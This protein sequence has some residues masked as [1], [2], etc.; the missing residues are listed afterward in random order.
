MLTFIS[1]LVTWVSHQIY[2][3]EKSFFKSLQTPGGGPRHYS[4]PIEYG[5]EA[6][7]SLRATAERL[8]VDPIRTEEQ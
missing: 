1:Q 4:A 7:T 5:E 6:M 8:G 3:I 2:T